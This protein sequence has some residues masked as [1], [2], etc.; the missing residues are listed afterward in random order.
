MK[1]GRPTH[2][3]QAKW[4]T[5]RDNLNS[6]MTFYQLN[7]AGKVETQSGRPVPHHRVR[8]D[9]HSALLLR[10]HVMEAELIPKTQS[11]GQATAADGAAPMEFT[12]SG[13][14]FDD[15]D[16]WNG[17]TYEDFGIDP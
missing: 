11:D 9:G 15:R 12:F 7:R 10:P 17:F 3:I 5:W 13:L 4:V 8:S 1:A 16:S 14:H 6:E 2:H